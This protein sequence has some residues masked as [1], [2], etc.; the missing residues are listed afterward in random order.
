[1]TDRY[2]RSTNGTAD[3][4]N[5]ST[6]ALAKTTLAGAAAIDAAGDTIWLSQ[7]HAENTA[8]AISIPLAGTL[9]SAVKILCGNDAAEPPT[10]LAKTASVTT[11][12]SGT[13]TFS[14]SGYI[15]GAIFTV[16]NSTSSASIVTGSNSLMEFNNCDLIFGGTGSSSKLQG[17]P[18]SVLRLSE[19][20]LQFN[21]T[22]VGVGITTDGEIVINGG[23]IISGGST[24]SALFRGATTNRGCSIIVKGFDFSNLASTFD[25]VG[26]ITTGWGRF[27]FRNCKMP[28]SW[29][30]D[31]MPT[32]TSVNTR[33]ELFNCDS[34]DTNYILWVS[35]YYGSIKSES[36]V[37]R[38]GGAV[39]GQYSGSTALDQLAWI[40]TSTAAANYPNG[41]LDSPEIVQWNDT[42]GSAITVTVEIATDNVTLTDAQ[43]WLEVQYLGTSGVPLSVFSSDSAGTSGGTT[44]ESVLTGLAGGTNQDSSSET[45]VNVPGTPV[46]Q[47]LSVTITPQER[48]F[49]HATIKLAKPSTT[50]YVDPKLTVT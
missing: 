1:M 25:L 11:T 10:A 38:T 3:A 26:A 21:S 14:G 4:D 40:M 31:L 43:C 45:W 48:G 24:P 36:S 13:V 41:A 20:R 29:S 16:G 49:I 2:V 30:G 27:I 17:G 28:T 33:A 37:G 7:V 19:T 23:S 47:K 18:G 22:N 42:V 32:P 5:G 8:G 46:K 6:W 9:G 12:G 39:G 35:D 50:V 44:T 34:S 15:Y